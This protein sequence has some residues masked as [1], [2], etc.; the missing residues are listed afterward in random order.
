MGQLKPRKKIQLHFCPN[1]LDF[2]S[3]LQ[4]KKKE[5][6]FW[7]SYTFN[8]KVLIII[9]DQGTG[10]KTKEKKEEEEKKMRKKRTRKKNV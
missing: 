10:R 1:W 6:S 5:Q 8:F 2:V 9:R 7:D 4:K 3:I